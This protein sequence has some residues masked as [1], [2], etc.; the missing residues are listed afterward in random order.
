[1]RKS[2]L[3]FT[4]ALI[5]ASSAAAGGLTTECGTLVP[6]VTCPLFFQADSGGLYLLDDY[7]AYTLGDV[8][9]VTG[10]VDPNC[11]NYCM[12][13]D[14]CI[15]VLAITSCGPVNVGVPYCFGDGSGAACTCANPGGTGEGCANSSGA[16]AVLM[17]TGSDSVAA[18]DLALSAS[19]LLGAQPALLFSGGNALN[20][21][22]G[23]LFG[24]G[25]RCAGG[26]VLRHGVALPAA[27][28]EASWPTGLA[29]AA[30]WSAGDVRHFQVW[31]RDPIGTPCG[32]SFNLTQGLTVTFSL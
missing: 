32:F 13:G 6:G 18:D 2:L 22:N 19:G 23:L 21:G 28:G 12:Q 20:G 25:L 31:Y 24:D 7:G 14:G 27:S 4:L 3:T 1:M 10:L 30:G 15:T 16:G 9:Q 8:V 5:T 11:I 26:S 29:A 17:A